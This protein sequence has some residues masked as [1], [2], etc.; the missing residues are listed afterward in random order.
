M[1]SVGDRATL[2]FVVTEADTAAQLGSGDV[3]V[4]GTPRLLAWLEAATVA[5][6]AGQVP[7]EE[8]TVGARVELT[9]LAPSPVGAEV[10]V[11]SQISEVAGRRI[12]FQVRATN[13][14]GQLVGEGE[15]LRVRAP[16]DRFA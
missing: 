2:H 12:T 4:L 13:P 16:R 15:I 10:A 11:T 1:I 7:V 8:T 6:L 3:G 14:D 5:A 9:H